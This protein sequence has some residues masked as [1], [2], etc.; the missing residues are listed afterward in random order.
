MMGVTIPLSQELENSSEGNAM[1]VG[2]SWCNQVDAV[3]LQIDPDDHDAGIIAELV[4]LVGNESK[5][6]GCVYESWFQWGRAG[7]EPFINP[8]A[9]KPVTVSGSSGDPP[10]PSA[11]MDLQ[12]SSCK[13][14]HRVA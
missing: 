10:N 3:A 13:A 9:A 6:G 7:P 2:A 4:D 11:S 1:P 8:P 14:G 12:A 5:L